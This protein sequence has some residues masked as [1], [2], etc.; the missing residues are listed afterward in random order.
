MTKFRECGEC[1]A[2]CTWLYGEVYESEFGNGKSCKFL[3]CDGCG[4]H[5]TRPSLCR[6]YQCAWSQYLLSEEMRPDKSNIIVSVERNEN[7]QYLNV[8]PIN[9]VEISEEIKEYFKNWSEKMNTP[10]I[11]SEIFHNNQSN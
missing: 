9:N 5:E 10:V 6:N 11:I 1:T 8:F 7:G 2:C 3:K 4:I